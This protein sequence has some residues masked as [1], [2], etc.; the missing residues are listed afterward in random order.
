MVRPLYPFLKKYSFI[1]RTEEDY[2]KSKVGDILLRYFAS[3]VVDPLEDLLE[4]IDPSLGLWEKQLTL[5]RSEVP[6]KK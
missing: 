2:C 5:S 4:K 6:E 3:L 1:S